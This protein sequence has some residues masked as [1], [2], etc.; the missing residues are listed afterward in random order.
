[1][2]RSGHGR[3][4]VYHGT[5]DARSGTRAA[6]ATGPGA[7]AAERAVGPGVLPGGGRQRAVVLRVA[8]EARSGRPQGTG[9]P[10]GA[11][12]YRRGRAG[13]YLLRA[14]P[15]PPSLGAARAVAVLMLLE[16]IDG[17]R[18]KPGNRYPCPAARAAI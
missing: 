12:H 16:G 17:W 9:I 7:V 8:A 4:G 3:K 1:M 14:S 5:S 15:G 18:A 6:L 10:P 2:L 13:R 11:R